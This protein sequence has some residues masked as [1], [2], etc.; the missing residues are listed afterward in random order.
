MAGR[1]YSGTTISLIK[2]EEPISKDSWRT[3]RIVITILGESA[4]TMPQIENATDDQWAD[5]I[6]DNMDEAFEYA[7]NVTRDSKAAYVA[8]P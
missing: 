5:F 4:A 7:A 2:S 6:Y 3:T 8:L 1:N